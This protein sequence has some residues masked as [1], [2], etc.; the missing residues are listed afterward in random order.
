MSD[1]E[2]ALRD[3]ERS[4][5]RKKQD[6]AFYR[7]EMLRQKIAGA[8]ICIASIMLWW[9]LSDRYGQFEWGL[10]MSC[11]IWLGLYL[12]LTRKN[13]HRQEETD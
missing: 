2:R 12:V 7:N 13:L 3:V 10:V 9:Y 11:G 8:L 4:L 6:E 1:M 5:A